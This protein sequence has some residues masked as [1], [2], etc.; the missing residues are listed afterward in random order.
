MMVPAA[1]EYIFCNL[2]L[3]TVLPTLFTLLIIL[4]FKVQNPKIA[5]T[6][7]TCLYLILDLTLLMPSEYTFCLLVN[8]YLK[9]SSGKYPLIVIPDGCLS[10]LIFWWQRLTNSDEIGTIP[11]LRSK[12]S[13]DSSVTEKEKKI[14]IS[15]NFGPIFLKITNSV[16]K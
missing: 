15:R 7:N 12:S 2:Y 14:V 1:L 6:L 11:V 16:T 4:Y 9:C 13:N 8:S 5:G 10:N 3:D